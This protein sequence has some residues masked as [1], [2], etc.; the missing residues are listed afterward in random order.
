MTSHKRNRLS[1]FKSLES[2]GIKRKDLQQISGQNLIRI[3]KKLISERKLNNTVSK[4]ETEQILLILKDYQTEIRAISYYECLYSILTNRTPAYMDSLR[5][6]TN[7]EVLRIRALLSG[8][9]K[10]DLLIYIA[11]NFKENKWNNLRI[12]LQFRIFLSEEIIQQLIIRMQSKLDESLAVLNQMPAHKVLR[13]NVG[14]LRKKEIYL[15][16][17]EIHLTHFT[18]YIKLFLDFFLYHKKYTAGTPFFDYFLSSMLTYNIADQ[19]MQQR[20]VGAMLKQGGQVRFVYFAYGLIAVVL[21][22]F[23]LAIPKRTNYFKQRT[24]FWA[25]KDSNGRDQYANSVHYLSAQQDLEMLNFVEA[26]LNPVQHTSSQSIPQVF[27]EKYG[28][29]FRIALFGY[30]SEIK[31]PVKQL[32]IKNLTENECVVLA[33]YHRFY[34]R[35]K[36]IYEPKNPNKLA[37]IYALYIPKNDSIQIDL[38]VAVLRF[39]MGKKLWGFNNYRE[40]VY[41]DSLDRKFSVFNPVD[42]VLFRYG[43]A[44]DAENEIRS[45]QQTLA[46]SQPD[47]SHYHLTW[48]GNSPLYRFTDYPQMYGKA[49]KLIKGD[50]L[51]LPEKRKATGQNPGVKE[52]HIH[53][54]LSRVHKNKTEEDVIF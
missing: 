51:V 11:T 15:L 3:E 19:R 6:H 25:D 24:N 52:E 8:H 23:Y 44:F 39:Y 54:F 30:P 35:Q 47:R 21:I 45:N 4:N 38:E 33:Y 41:S 48:S 40:F 12:L 1:F 37:K 32:V 10:E 42:S 20:I 22:C 43:F 53:S 27:I 14:Y 16:M 28:N 31:N 46:I 17:N 34:N 18:P 9:F 5:F 26:R 50:T 2:I 29:P 36:K 7:D 13:Q 49:D